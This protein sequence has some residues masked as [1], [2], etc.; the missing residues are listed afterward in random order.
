VNTATVA[1]SVDVTDPTPANNSA[2][3]TDALGAS[4]DVSVAKVAVGVPDPL[5]I[6]SAF[7]Y[8]LTA[9][10]AGPSV[11]TGVV[12]SD[13]LP[14]TLNYVSNDCGAAFAAPTLTWNIGNLAPGAAPVC[15]LNVTVAALGQIV[16]TASVSSTSTDPVPANDASTV[17]LVGAQ[18]ADVAI[19]LT[20]SA[21]LGTLAVGDT[22]TYTV[23]GTNNGPGVAVTL[24]FSL[25]LASKVSFVSSTCG[26]TLTGNT[27]NW[28]VA[29]LAS[30]ASTD[31]VITVVVVLGGEI[32]ALANVSTISV[33]P[34]LENNSATLAVATGAI[35]VP[36]LGW[37]GLSLLLILVAA[38]GTI[39]VRR[40]G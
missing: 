11:A 39:I 20:S 10:N 32:Q 28:T 36:A 16:N 30:G 33:D 4:A 1:T 5:L 21:G 19:S 37:M 25:E 13:T 9:A 40:H 22:Y 27:L 8:T 34:V 6:G 31:C 12:V 2:T 15:N 18:P 26:A 7:S 3:D 14:A 38:M 24:D 23:T 17:T 29:T 35:A